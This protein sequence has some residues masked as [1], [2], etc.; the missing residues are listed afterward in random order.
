MVLTLLKQL[1]LYVYSVSYCIHNC[2]Y[3]VL[4]LLNVRSTLNGLNDVCM[5]YFV[6]ALKEVHMNQV[7]ILILNK[8]LSLIIEDGV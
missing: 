5:E 7:F 8:A 4:H 6:F 2:N 3:Y 1:Y